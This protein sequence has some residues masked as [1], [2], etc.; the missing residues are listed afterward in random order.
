MKQNQNQNLFLIMILLIFFLPFMQTMVHFLP[1]PIL[2][3]VEDPQTKPTYNSSDF[4][5]GKFQKDFNGW[6]NQ[7]LGLRSY[8]LKTYNQIFY[9]FFNASPNT[10]VIIGKKGYLF[11]TEYINDYCIGSTLPKS[12]VEI[13]AKQ[14]KDVQNIF[15]SKGIC[16]ILNITPSKAAIYPEYIPDNLIEVKN[17]TRNYDLFIKYLDKY[18]VNYVDG[19]LITQKQK[20]TI[21]EP[22]FCKS[23]LHWN[24]FGAYFTTAKLLNKVEE[25]TK[26]DLPNIH[27][28]NLIWDNKPIGS[29]LDLARLLNL[30]ITP[31]KNKTPH[32]EFNSNADKID[33]KP[34]ILIIGDS[35]NW[36][37]LDI[38]DKCHVSSQLDLYYYYESQYNYPYGNKQPLDRLNWDEEIFNRDVIILSMNE[39]KIPT[40]GFGFISDVIT[41][42]NQNNLLDEKIE[43]LNLT[44]VEETIIDNKKGYLIKKGA[45]SGTVYLET[46]KLI[47]EPAQKY[48]ISYKA[49]GFPVLKCDLYPDSLPNFDNYN[50]SDTFKDFIYVF[51]TNDEN[52]SNC[53]LRFFIDG[54]SS[55]VDK[56]SYIYDIKLVKTP[57][58]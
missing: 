26:R 44:Y 24:L 28:E 11:E 2:A 57:K 9:T 32:L 12:D 46:K 15:Q 4:L 25:L 14:I 22:L 1:E 50:V 30:W 19:H 8:F 40:Y 48:Q 5:T 3:G 51:E 38:L 29:D 27:Y 41:V 17:K 39:V 35:F 37:I 52:I 53:S 33:F 34:N 6:F 23:G 21:N 55:V 56:D 18:G 7:N 43:T 20:K 58:H 54:I 31:S 49:K 13:M 45:P 36:Q 10:S 42:M 47:L 16:F